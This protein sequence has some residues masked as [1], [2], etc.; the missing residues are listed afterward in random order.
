MSRFAKAN[1]ITLEYFVE[2]AKN[3]NTTKSTNNWVNVYKQWASERGY[4]QDLEK[5]SFGEVDIILCL[6]FAEIRKQNGEDYEPDSLR[7]MQSSLNRYLLDRS[8]NRNILKDT[9]FVKSRNILEGKARNLRK[10]GKGK[11]PNAST[12]ITEKEENILWDTGKL[13]SNSP[14]SLVHTMWFIN[15]QYFGLRGNQEHVTMC[16]NNFI[17]KLDE[18]GVEYIE[19]LEDITKTRQKGLHHTK[20]VTNTKMFATN[21]PRCP[22]KLWKIYVEHRPEDLRNT[23][24]F[25]LTPLPNYSTDHNVWYKRTPIGKNCIGLIMKSL[26]SGTDVENAGKRLTNHSA[27]KTLIKKLKSAKIPESSIIKVTGH[28]HTDGLKNYDPGDE[29]EFKEMSN[30]IEIQRESEPQA[31]ISTSTSV[32]SAIQIYDPVFPEAGP[33]L[34][35]KGRYIFQNCSNVKIN[36]S[37][38]TKT[39]TKRKYIIESS[40]SSQEI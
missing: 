2:S 33:S 8:Y 31:S 24:R 13:G 26:I 35:F 7:V 28:K 22:V 29:E 39:S 40:D 15:T 27:R 34:T 21:G 3:Q 37:S 17:I 36:L 38:V 16:M 19:F 20:R 12:F 6:F 9:E 25:Y 18:K 5:Y 11:R 32:N 1:E 10:E 30:A 23:G 4:D 14:K